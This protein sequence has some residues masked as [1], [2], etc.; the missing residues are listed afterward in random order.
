M[1]I[2]MTIMIRINFDII[3]KF[4]LESNSIPKINSLRLKL[5]FT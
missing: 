1:I 4:K 2:E 5:S 3:L